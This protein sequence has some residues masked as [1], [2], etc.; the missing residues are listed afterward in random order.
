MD[1]WWLHDFEWWGV[2]FNLPVG[3]GSGKLGFAEVHYSE[4]NGKEPRLTRQP[5]DPGFPSLMWIH[6]SS[7]KASSPFCWLGSETQRH[8]GAGNAGSGVFCV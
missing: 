2:F 8:F 7:N 5:S 3:V 4:T 6:P 1:Y